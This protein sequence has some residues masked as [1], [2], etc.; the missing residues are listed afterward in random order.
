VGLLLLV[1]LVFN[2]SSLPY[3]MWFKIGCLLLIPVALIAGSRMAM[4][5]KIEVTR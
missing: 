4:R 1:A 2:I 5:P 3:P